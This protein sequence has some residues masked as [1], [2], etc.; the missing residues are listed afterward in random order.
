MAVGHLSIAE[1]D[2]ED[3]IPVDL[4]MQRLEVTDHP[5]EI[6]RGER[7]SVV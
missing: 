7:S 1:E 2:G 5:H 6:L 3:L 4:T